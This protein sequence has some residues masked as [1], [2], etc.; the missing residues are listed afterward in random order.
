MRILVL[1]LLIICGALQYRLW[2]GQHSIKEYL[3]HK[4]ELR[5]H[6]QS[7]LEL[8]KRKHELVGD[9]IHTDVSALKQLSR[10]ELVDL[11]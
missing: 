10:K 4:E 7:N 6:Q 8:Q 1:I 11:L 3:Q 5:T 9:L 2:L